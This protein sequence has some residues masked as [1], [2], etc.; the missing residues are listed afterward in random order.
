MTIS[1]KR[2]V[3]IVALDPAELGG[4]GQTMSDM[5]RPARSKFSCAGNDPRSCM[6]WTIIN[7]TK[8]HSSRMITQA[9]SE[10]YAIRKC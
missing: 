7:P 4:P 10:P 3:W 6:N 5:H 9:K 1:C 8:A 2:A